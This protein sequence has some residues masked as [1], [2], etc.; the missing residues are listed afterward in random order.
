MSSYRFHLLGIAHTKTRQDYGSCAFTQKV[1]KMAQMLTSLGHEVYHYGAEG[2]NPPCTEHID[3]ISTAM[4]QYSYDD[5]DLRKNANIIK[6]GLNDAAYQEFNK[7]AIEEINK[8]KQPRDMLLISMGNLQKPIA[9]ATGV[10]AIEMGIGYTGHWA[11]YKVFESYAWMHY[12][13]GVLYPAWNACDGRF[14]DC[15]IP[16]YWDPADFSFSDKKD[17]YL[18]YIGRVIPRKGVH[19]AAQ[20]AELTGSRLVIAGAGD[21]NGAGITKPSHRIEYLGHVENEQRAELMSKARAVL[22]PT[23]YLEPFGGVS[24]EAM[25]SGTPAI[26]TDWGGFTEVINH[27]VTGY[28]CRSMDDFIWAVNHA[29]DLN[30]HDCRRWAESNY[31]LDRVKLMYHEWFGKLQDL[32]AKGWYEEHPERDNLDWLK[33][34]WP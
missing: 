7:R 34:I 25:L 26:T 32:F 16:N 6:F 11:Q 12:C 27:G 18:L 29:G 24:V 8:R 19:V 2:S 23:L 14:Y 30:P 15:V 20:V 5:I 4:Q 13:Y 17:D 10:M 33:R 31:S 3:C 28:R 1:Y 9:D 22:V 21:L